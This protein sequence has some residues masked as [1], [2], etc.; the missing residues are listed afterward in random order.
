MKFLNQIFILNIY[1]GFLGINMEQRL[2]LKY[3]IKFFENGKVTKRTL[4]DNY[5]KGFALRNIVW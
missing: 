1:S 2:K 5:D 4:V 3:R